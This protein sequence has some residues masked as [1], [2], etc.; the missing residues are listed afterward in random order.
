MERSNDTAPAPYV[1]PLQLTAGAPPPVAAHGG[2][3]YMSFD[4]DGDAGTAEAIRDTMAQ[5]AGGKVQAFVEKRPADFT[6]AAL[7]FVPQRSVILSQRMVMILSMIDQQMP[8]MVHTTDNVRMPANLTADNAEAGFH[9]MVVQYVQ[10][11]RRNVVFQIRTVVERQHDFIR[12]E[13]GLA[14]VSTQN[15]K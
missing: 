12:P 9:T 8:G 2:L 4:Q 14:R 11:F 10:K 13:S 15:R 7:N 3:S 5:M 6:I 1:P